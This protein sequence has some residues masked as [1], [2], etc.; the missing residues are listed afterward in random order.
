MSFIDEL[1]QANQKRREAFSDEIRK[2]A[3]NLVDY[4]KNQMMRN[5]NMGDGNMQEVT[6]TAAIRFDAANIGLKAV[7]EEK[8]DE[9]ISAARYLYIDTCMKQ[10]DG[11]IFCLR[12]RQEYDAFATLVEASAREVGI[13]EIEKT[14]NDAKNIAAMRFTVHLQ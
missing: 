13:T 5:I 11:L 7:S 9:D 4:V 10:G 6:A 3:K 2:I 14:V 1:N 12:S 8:A